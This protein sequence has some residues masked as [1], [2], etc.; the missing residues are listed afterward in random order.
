VIHTIKKHWV[1]IFILT[2]L[3]VLS[4]YLRFKHLG[5]SEYIPDE[6]AVLMPLKENGYYTSAFLLEQRKGP[7]QY[8]VSHIPYLLTLD[9]LNEFV[10][11]IPFALSSILAI[12]F[13][14]KLVKEITNNKWIGF[15]SALLL[16][17][18][19]FIVAFGRIVQYQSLNMLFSFIALYLFAKHRPV[20]G[21]VFLGLSL[22]SH[23][24]VVYVLPVI[25]VLL[26]KHKA[27]FGVL[28]KSS[29]VGLVVVLPFLLPYGLNYIKD[30]SNQ[31][32]FASRAGVD[33]FSEIDFQDKVSDYLFRSE[34]YNP[35]LLTSFILGAAVL[36]LLSPKRSW[37]FYLWFGFSLL[38]FIFFIRKPGTHVYNM[39]IPLSVLAGIG[40]YNCFELIFKIGSLAGKFS[41]H[42]RIGFSTL[43]AVP[44]VCV[45]GFLVYQTNA[46][47]IDHSIEYPWQQEH[48]S[49]GKAEHLE[50]FPWLAK[51]YPA[52]GLELETKSY[53]H[54]NLTNNII[55]FPLYRNWEEANRFL[56][57]ENSKNAHSL[58]YI[59]NET[60]SIA[61]F[62]MDLPYE[63]DLGSSY[64]AIGVKRPLSFVKDYKFSQIKGKSTIHKVADAIGDT[65]IR[66]YLVE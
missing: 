63:Y 22:L 3:V 42:L 37:I 11:R 2:L 65:V 46:V 61:A 53:D 30:S 50:K 12:V 28:V 59:T 56:L 32:Y 54:T 66:I 4:F 27:K 43:V 33:N 7:I 55:G 60:R 6:V 45:Y 18:N 26:I 23:W 29:L 20:W 51:I 40:I 31:E 58:G 47:F 39:F 35:F 57:E 21:T 8:L 1:E 52:Y 49:F 48:L 38:F 17:V 14:Y 25:A 24:D 9:I 10:M 41:K 36:S 13:F 34:L 5:Y 16:T 44:L 19:G 62:Y 15:F 64:Y